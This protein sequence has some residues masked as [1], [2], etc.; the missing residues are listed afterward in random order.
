MVA[1]TLH[2]TRLRFGPNN[3]RKN[4]CI[5]KK[6]NNTP[7]TQQLFGKRK[8]KRAN[9]NIINSNDF[10]FIFHT[11]IYRSS[12]NNQVFPGMEYTVTLSQRWSR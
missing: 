8:F 5:F 10:F 1:C 7:T 9:V 6:L 2:T 11:K 3:S 12:Y 4:N